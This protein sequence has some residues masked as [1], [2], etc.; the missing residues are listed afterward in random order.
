[1]KGMGVP[2]KTDQF[3]SFLTERSGVQESVSKA[4]SDQQK[5][6]FLHAQE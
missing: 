5:G 4:F 3:L 6:R 2:G 1:M